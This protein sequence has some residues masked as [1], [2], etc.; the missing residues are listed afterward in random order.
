MKRKEMPNPAASTVG[1]RS[2][3]RITPIEGS[4]LKSGTALRYPSKAKI[5][6]MN[7]RASCFSERELSFSEVNLPATLVLSQCNEG[8]PFDPSFLRIPFIE[9]RA[10]LPELQHQLPHNSE[11]PQ[12]AGVHPVIQK[13][14]PGS[15]VSIRHSQSVH[16]QGF[17]TL[18]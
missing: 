1:C 6:P 15:V 12:D 10:N 14:F 18:P 5:K 2:T 4:H 7:S 8:V 3:A 11:L 9:M 13:H 17:Q 16:H